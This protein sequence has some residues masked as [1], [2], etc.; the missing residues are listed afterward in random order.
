MD[1]ATIKIQRSILVEQLVYYENMIDKFMKLKQIASDRLARNEDLLTESEGESEDEEQY[2][3]E[4]DTE[5]V[6][7]EKVVVDRDQAF[8]VTPIN[9]N[10]KSRSNVDYSEQKHREATGEQM[11]WDDTRHNS[12][13]AAGGLFAFVHNNRMVEICQV[14]KVCSPK[15]RL[16]S[17]SE[18]VG[19]SKRNV[20]ELTNVLTTLSWDEWISNGGHSKVQGTT[21]IRANK[22]MLIDFIETRI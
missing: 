12:T 15:H 17:W 3:E 6:A 10:L 13:K 19:Q 18:N 2:M 5:E 8:I 1:T 4:T 20:L 16:E 11:M 14:T 7:A 22:E 9:K 21:Q